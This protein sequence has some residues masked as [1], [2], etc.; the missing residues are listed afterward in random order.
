MVPAVTLGSTYTSELN[1]AYDYGY[2]MG[3]TTKSS[4]DSANMF[5]SLIRA[6]MA[7]M[8]SNYAVEVLG[9]TP[10]TSMDCDYSDMS[11]QTVEMQDYAVE[12]C[13]LG[14]M[15]LNSDGT[16][17]SMF[18][19]NG[20]VTRAQFGTV[21]SRA[22]YG[23]MYNGGD[24]RYADH[25]DALQAD[26]VMNSIS[27]PFA[28]EVRGYV[29]LMM[30]RADE[31]GVATNEGSICND[32]I[33]IALCAIGD[34]ACPAEC[35]VEDE[36]EILDGSITLSSDGV[37]YT[38]IPMAGLV[39]FGAMEFATDGTEVTVNS[40]TIKNVG[41]STLDSATR[42]FFEQ[43]GVRISGRAS[44]TN[45]EA[46]ISFTNPL[47]VKNSESVDVILSLSGASGDEYQF[48]STVLDSSAE[49][50]YGEWES[51]LLRAA[52]YTV[53]AV[54]ANGN[55]TAL[56]PKV[57]SAKLVELGQVDITKATSTKYA[58]VKAI[59]LNNS[60]SA[61]LSM[62][63]DAAIYRDDVQVSTKTTIDNRVISF[64]IE[65]EIKDTQTS[66]IS[67]VVKAKIAD[68][69]RVGDTYNLY[70]KNTED[71]SVV[72][73]DTDFR[74]TITSTASSLATITVA[75]G[76][77][78]FVESTTASLDVVPGT[79]TVKFYDGAVT[80]YQTVSLETFQ[81]TATA[82]TGFDLLL[83]NLYLKIGG[84]VVAV[85]EVTAG[86]ALTGVFDGAITINGT[87]DV[88]IYGDIKSNAP[89]ATINGWSAFSLNSVTGVKE[90]T[91]NGQTITS[92]I[93]SI[94]GR[95]VNIVE[96][97]LTLSNSSSAT[98]SVQRGDRD[99]LLADLEFGTTS[100]VVSKL[101]S[102]KGTLTGTN[103]GNFDGAQITIYNDGVALVSD[104]VTTGNT[105]VTFVLPEYELIAKGSPLN[106][107]VELDQV[108]NA[109]STGGMYLG[110]EINTINAKET[111]NS[112]AVGA[113]LTADT[114]LLWSVIGGTVSVITQTYTQLL[115]KAGDAA[116]IGA[117]NLK[118]FNGDAVL[119]TMTLSGV[120]INKISS[121]KLVE[122]GVAVA[123]FT[124]TGT[125][126]YA[127][128]INKTIAVGES[129]NYD[130]EATFSS[131]STSGDLAAAYTLYME[132]AT[133]ESPYGVSL[134]ALTSS[135]ISA[136]TTVVNDVLSITAIE[137]LRGSNYASY[138][139]S[140]DSTEQTK[141][142][143]MTIALG[144]NLATS[145]SGAT[146]TLSSSYNAG[147]TV[148]ATGIVWPTLAALT[149]TPATAVDVIGAANLYITVWGVTWSAT[150]GDP[151][152]FIGLSDLSYSDVFDDASLAPH[153][154]VL[155]TY[156]DAMTTII[157]LGVNVQ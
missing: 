147:G 152:V 52:N 97:D 94:G 135:A 143:A 124:K 80:A 22:L 146:V 9:L 39:S 136:A 34:S 11:N 156:K 116:T 42:V 79:Q 13:Q 3:I 29:M 26:G 68:A 130:V 145:I 100:D 111:I 84:S 36:T 127:N 151:Y 65:D 50:L 74:T 142:T 121:V 90:Y 73:K 150:N 103:Y 114:T 17:A 85:T 60:G 78:K 49:D 2:D 117:V 154:N 113:S 5:G 76:D 56:N 120:D 104:T 75:G 51:P 67:Y 88:E 27:N 15:G 1:D 63:D 46:V 132:A 118:A 7:K 91:D 92:S 37:D 53:L 138:K 23:D 8:M 125:I 107:T 18:N 45:N 4:I 131:A 81:I 21:M 70:I 35:L 119:K 64:V 10:D 54:T 16:P 14:L 48:V 62:L 59:T 144:E 102:F 96:A 99:V 106:L 105:V 83:Q 95:T 30:M 31:A 110:M 157:D 149:L 32:D 12:A 25:L 134:T 141:V 139:L 129:L 137:G 128:N 33:T 89:A 24:V 47:V 101:Y 69:D 43:D 6:H 72:E 123:T 126:L 55:G 44:F 98:K 40:V 133:F 58:V 140:L 19:P 57:D 93:G 122:D 66:I 108:P 28:P 148:Y 20:I 61:D 71:I 112:N 155:S 41:L 87:E 115:V 86:T 153:A 82:T 77:L 38:S 109:V